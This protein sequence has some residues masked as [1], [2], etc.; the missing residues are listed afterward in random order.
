MS[1]FL[2]RL[3]LPS[4]YNESK[5]TQN[6]LFWKYENYL[7]TTF[8]PI[9]GEMPFEEFNDKSGKFKISIEHI[10]AQTPKNGLQFRN[11]DDEF[12]ENF[13]HCLGNLTID[14]QSSNSSKGNEIWENKNEKY[15]QKAPFK[16]QLELSDFVDN[17]TK[18]WDETCIGKRKDKIIDIAKVL[19][20]V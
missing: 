9:C 1:D 2:A 17:S 14:P 7:R 6:F 3:R 11:I 10:T 15:F 20:A 5:K 13:L 18:R 12:R 4:F 8:Q 19:W 16:T